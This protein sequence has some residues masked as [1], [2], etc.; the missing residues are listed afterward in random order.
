MQAV[1]ACSPDLSMRRQDRFILCSLLCLLL[2]PAVY[3]FGTVQNATVSVKRI[4]HPIPDRPYS[5]ATTDRGPFENHALPWFGK[6]R[7][8]RTIIDGTLYQDGVYDITFYGGWFGLPRDMLTV[9]TIK[10][11]RPQAKIILP[12]MQ[13]LKKAASPQ[14]APR[15]FSKD[16]SGAGYAL[17]QDEATLARRIFGTEIDTDNIRIYFI[18]EDKKDIYST[19]DLTLDTRHGSSVKISFFGKAYLSDDF[20][21]AGLEAFFCFIHEMTHV[22]QAQT[23]MKATRAYD[24]Q[25]YRYALVENYSFTRFSNEQQAA[26]IEDY[27]RRFL[28]TSPQPT[29]YYLN[30]ENLFGQ[31]GHDTAETDALLKKTVEKIFKI[32]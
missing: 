13:P 15:Q 12:K 5:I 25:T 24:P 10:D 32:K 29:T 18:D 3:R 14:P 19:T 8:A 30:A 16:T 26:I 9:K 23:N 4:S 21:H 17:T 11:P 2:L 20:A 22:W 31:L 28:G 7:T 1:S 6:T 27:A